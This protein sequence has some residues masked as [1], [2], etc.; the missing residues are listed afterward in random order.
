MGKRLDIA[1]Q[2]FGCLT[3]VSQAA[4][5]TTP[6]GATVG[7]WVVMCKCGRQK[8][9]KVQALVKNG[10]SSCGAGCVLR[11]DAKIAV[12][13]GS[14]GSGYLI[15]RDS[16]TKNQ[17]RHGNARHCCR[18]CASKLASSSVIG[19]P[20]PNRLPE[21]HAAFN[22]LYGSYKRNARQAGVEFNL[23][24]VQFKELTTMNCHYCGT[25][26]QTV[27]EPDALR[28][29]GKTSGAYIYNGIDKVD[30]KKGYVIGNVVPCCHRCNVMKTNIPV[31][32]FLAHVRAIFMHSVLADS[33]P[34][35]SGRRA[36][37]P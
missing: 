14:C 6:S 1:G 18:K 19:K 15:R 23:S 24:N 20:A 28:S 33:V 27:R 10:H 25:D 11:A 32:V 2:E 12:A 26:P 31:S 5:R 7:Y 35:K 17:L 29:K 34:P 21:G 36:Y 16:I 9:M 30:P 22:S 37:L 8:E 3:A 13:C 4:S